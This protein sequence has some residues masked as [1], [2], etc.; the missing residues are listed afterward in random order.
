MIFTTQQNR[1]FIDSAI[2][3]ITIEDKVESNITKFNIP[4]LELA[5]IDST[6]APKAIIKIN[7][8]NDFQAAKS[9]NARLCCI[10]LENI[11]NLNFASKDIIVRMKCATPHIVYIISSFGFGGILLDKL[12][13]DGKLIHKLITAFTKHSNFYHQI[14]QNTMQILQINSID[15]VFNEELETKNMLAESKTKDSTSKYNT[16]AL[17]INTYS[18]QILQ[19]LKS[20]KKA[21]SIGIVD[22]DEAYKIATRLLQANLLDSM[23]L[24]NLG[25][26]K[27]YENTYLSFFSDEFGT[28]DG[29]YNIIYQK[30]NYFLSGLRG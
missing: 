3:G 18:K 25:L 9:V 15:D 7:N 30:F 21:V 11:L 26:P 28:L 17:S 22:N 29:A 4:L 12:A 20:N 10:N 23:Y 1:A 16:I 27:H 8:I 13:L 5:K 6:I 24:K 14:F 19:F 2:S